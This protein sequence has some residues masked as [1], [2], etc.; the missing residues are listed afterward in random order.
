MKKP[1]P[2]YDAAEEAI[3]AQITNPRPP[4]KASTKHENYD[5]MSILGN[6]NA[7][8]EKLA[9]SKG[10]TLE[11]WLAMESEVHHP[12]EI[13]AISPSP[14]MMARR[15]MKDAGVPERFIAA[16]ADK[17]PIDC[18]PWRHVRDFL[19][20]RDSFRVLKGGK[21]IRKTGSACWAL[22]QLDGGAFIEADDVIRV[23]I[24]DKPRWEKILAASLVVFDDLGTER[25]DD[26]AIFTS[27]FS[28]LLNTVYSQSRRLLITCNLS[29]QTFRQVYGEREYDR[30]K[31]AGQWSTIA[32]ESVRHY[33]EREPG[34][35]DD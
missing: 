15:R 1:E 27:A 20:S 21:G 6:V 19:N 28:K 29:P 34:A 22:G 31:E 17:E 2:D 5:A 13:V 30:L 4:P 12:A 10:Y 23:S 18:E 32:G 3:M 33:T 25:R 7:F 24:E 8:R 26:K 35:D 14:R 16:V 11:Q 9:K